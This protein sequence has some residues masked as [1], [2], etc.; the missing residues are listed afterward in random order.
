ISTT[1]LRAC[2]IIMHLA[3]QPCH[4]RRRSAHK[5]LHFTAVS[6]AGAHS[7]NV[8]A[9]LAMGLVLPLHNQS[10]FFPQHASEAR[11]SPGRIKNLA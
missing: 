9:P 3:P 1:H 2:T 5:P 10:N 7:T 6:L 11:V 8:T 4:L